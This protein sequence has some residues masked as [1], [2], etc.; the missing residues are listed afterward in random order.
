MNDPHAGNDPSSEEPTEH[1]PEGAFPFERPDKPE[2]KSGE[3]ADAGEEEGA[4]HAPDDAGDAGTA[5]TEG[6]ATPASEPEPTPPEPEPV[7]PEPPTPS[8][9]ASEGSQAGATAPPPPAGPPQQS[10]TWA[11]A[12]H[13][14]TLVTFPVYFATANTPLFNLPGV[15]AALVMWQALKESRP[16]AVYHAKEAFNFQVN[17]F[18]I[19]MG[20]SVLI[21][22]GI[23]CCIGLPFWI[24][25][26]IA[27]VVFTII[28]AIEAANGKRYRY[29]FIW[30]PLD[31]EKLG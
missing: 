18:L 8:E 31:P 9:P 22:T 28:A 30:R 17:V 15:L 19:Q 21:M 4:S 6:T 14:A 20:A 2:A 24:T 5:G 25:I 10:D 7:A 12:S 23:F 11:A 1:K 26:N 29:P 27:N 3:S 13:L 16:E